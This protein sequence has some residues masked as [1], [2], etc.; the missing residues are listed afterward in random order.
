[1]CTMGSQN[2]SFLLFYMGLLKMLYFIL[3]ITATGTIYNFLQTGCYNVF[4]WPILN[5]FDVQ[6]AIGAISLFQLRS[7]LEFKSVS[8][9]VLL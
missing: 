4:T 2:P 3:I 9:S 1:M 8:T 6:T 7:D 5:F